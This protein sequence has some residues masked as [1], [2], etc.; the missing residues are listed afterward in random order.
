MLQVKLQSKRNISLKIG[1]IGWMTSD[2]SKINWIKRYLKKQGYNKVIVQEDNGM[3][4]VK[5]S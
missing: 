5:G 2:K 3:Y 1:Q 4:V